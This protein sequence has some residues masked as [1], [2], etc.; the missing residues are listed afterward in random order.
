MLRPQKC[1]DGGDHMELYN[2]PQQKAVMFREPLNVL[3]CRLFSI[4]CVSVFPEPFINAELVLLIQKYPDSLPMHVT[5]CLYFLLL[6]CDLFI[7]LKRVIWKA[8]LCLLA[9]TFRLSFTLL[10][11]LELI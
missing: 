9:P 3:L 11:C 10:K 7:Q 4:C 5:V 2:L 6:C 8:P 1:E